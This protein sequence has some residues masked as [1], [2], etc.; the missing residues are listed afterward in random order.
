VPRNYCILRKANQVYFERMKR[1]KTKKKH[2]EETVYTFDEYQKEKFK[3]NLARKGINELNYIMITINCPKRFYIWEPK[4]QLDYLINLLNSLKISFVACIEWC[5][6]RSNGYHLHIIIS[7]GDLN[8]E[9]FPNELF[10]DDLFYKSVLRR[11]HC[12]DRCLGYLTKERKDCTAF[13]RK[14]KFYYSN[15]KERKLIPLSTRIVEKEK[16]LIEENEVT[17]TSNETSIRRDPKEILRRFFT[18]ALAYVRRAFSALF[19]RKKS[20]FI[21]GNQSF[22]IRQNARDG[23]A[24]QW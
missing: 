5:D 7:K 1:I 16:I 6:E 23:P 11:N 8:V 14:E 20:V 15:I 18:K 3:S 22:H 10:V 2:F 12:L 13:N 19:I 24:R 21:D 17:L 4:K 9:L